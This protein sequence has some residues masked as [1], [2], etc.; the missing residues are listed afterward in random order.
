MFIG[1]KFNLEKEDKVVLDYIFFYIKYLVLEN[2]NMDLED[3]YNLL[4][5]VKNRVFNYII[6]VVYEINGYELEFGSIILCNYYK[7]KGMEWDCVFLL[8]FVEY[9]FFDN[10][11]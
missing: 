11:N 5:D 6:D 7:L 1:K 10:I 9:N 3:V 2:I 4:F 8:G